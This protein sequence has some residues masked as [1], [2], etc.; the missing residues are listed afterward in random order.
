MHNWKLEG[1]GEP[2]DN[3]E[4]RL[5][6]LRREETLLPVG[7]LPAQRAESV[8]RG[9]RDPSGH[10][11]PHH[12]EVGQSF[13]RGG[14]G[15]F[16]GRGERNPEFKFGCEVFFCTAENKHR[17][18]GIPLVSFL[19]QDILGNTTLEAI[20]FLFNAQFSVKWTL[21]PCMRRENATFRQE[22][23]AKK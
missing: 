14:H 22:F 6:S 17:I 2:G 4:Q 13:R 1:R 21:N 10:E 3:S 20:F 16:S 23:S 18:K 8:G 5:P 11:Q 15:H 7:R 19:Y 12:A 9:D